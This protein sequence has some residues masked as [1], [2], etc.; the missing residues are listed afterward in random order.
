LKGTGG[1][2]NRSEFFWQISV[3][4]MAENGQIWLKTAKMGIKKGSQLLKLTP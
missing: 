2:K 3:I 1:G 4:Q